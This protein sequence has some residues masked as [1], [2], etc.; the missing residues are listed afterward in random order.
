MAD[1]W[2]GN[3]PDWA[4]VIQHTGITETWTIFEGDHQATPESRLEKLKPVL[5]LIPPT[6][7]GETT[8]R[9]YF[10]KDVYEAILRGGE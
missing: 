2:T 6:D 1:A 7:T 8:K 4:C 5:D 9:W 3:E 10:T